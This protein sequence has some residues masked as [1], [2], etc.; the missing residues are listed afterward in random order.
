MQDITG[1]VVGCEASYCTISWAEA[2]RR[3]GRRTA[4]FLLQTTPHSKAGRMRIPSPGHT[5]RQ[6]LLADVAAL[7][8]WPTHAPLIFL[9]DSAILPC[10]RTR[11]RILN[12]WQVWAVAVGGPIVSGLLLWGVLDDMQDANRLTALEI[13]VEHLEEQA[14]KTIEIVL[15]LLQE[16]GGQ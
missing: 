15:G 5:L 14:T 1:H 16:S 7:D 13:R 10:Y 11:R 3:Y 9:L 4:L 2:V 12:T 6:Q 8:I